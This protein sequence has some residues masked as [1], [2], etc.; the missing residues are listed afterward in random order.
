MRDAAASGGA[1][2]AGQK[3]EDVAHG[4]TPRRD[5]TLQWPRSDR[6]KSPGL[7]NSSGTIDSSY[8]NSPSRHRPQNKLLWR[9]EDGGR[10]PQGRLDLRAPVRRRAQLPTQCGRPFLLHPSPPVAAA[11]PPSGGLFAW[12][13][14]AGTARLDIA[15]SASFHPV[16]YLQ[17]DLL[18]GESIN[19][20]VSFPTFFLPPHV[21]TFGTKPDIYWV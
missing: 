13:L 8:D 1:G 5:G 14:T 20:N 7:T 3:T 15:Q 2:G 16:L 18:G 17:L 21:S 9:S 4:A 19:I 10:A 6:A 11:R 12:P